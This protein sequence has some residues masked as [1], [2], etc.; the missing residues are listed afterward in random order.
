[1][2]RIYKLFVA[3]VGVSTL[4]CPGVVL[5]A[6]LWQW[7]GWWPGRGR[8]LPLLLQMKLRQVVLACS[9]LRSMPG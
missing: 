8:V 1:M 3:K 7:A 5:A 2:D 4:D 9:G 6:W